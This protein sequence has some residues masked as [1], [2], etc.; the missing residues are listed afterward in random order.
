MTPEERAAHELDRSEKYMQWFNACK[1]ANLQILIISSGVLGRRRCPRRVKV[2]VP[3]ITAWD[4]YYLDEEKVATQHP[5]KPNWRVSAH[6]TH[7]CGLFRLD[8]L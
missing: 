1:A 6:N 3:H 7:M 2:C 4:F 8:R 5:S